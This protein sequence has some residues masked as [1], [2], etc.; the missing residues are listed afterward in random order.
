MRATRI[1]KTPLF[2]LAL[3]LAAGL[4]PAALAGV[5][6]ETVTFTKH[7]ARILQN[8]CQDCHHPN[9]IAPMTL[10]S[11][12][13]VK[14]WAKMIREVVDT[15]RMPPWHASPEYGHFSNDRSMAQTDADM[16]MSW[17]DNGMP[18]GDPADM[19]APKTYNDE[20]RIDEPDV[21]LTMP[22]E[23]HIEPSGV[24]PYE[25]IE[26]PTGFEEDKWVTQIDIRAGNPKVVHHVLVYAR[27]PEHQEQEMGEFL[28][29][30]R[31]FI[32]G[33]APGTVPVI[34][35]G[36][37]AIK[38]PKGANLIFQMHYTPTGKPEVDRS[39]IGL[40]FAEK[41]PEFEDLTAT[42][43]NFDFKIPPHADN[44]EVVADIEFP[45]SALLY[46]MTPH[47]HYRGKGFTYTAKYPDGT[48][49]ILLDVPRFD[50]NWQTSYVLETPRYIPAGTVLHTVAHFDNSANNPANPDPSKP[51]RWGDQTWEEMMIGWMTI[52]WLSPEQETKFASLDGYKPQPN[53]AQSK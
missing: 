23:V 29:L 48:E 3:A 27:A 14:G 8:N 12:R 52:S 7:V 36:T 53:V 44:H 35:D 17:I 10:Q 31:G 38:I 33:Y 24:M 21:V 47:M 2:G 13:Q 5:E 26:I 37:R 15:K 16:L 34:L 30:G 46:S 43:I 6:S 22:E 32:A 11:Y 19:P 20:W 4:C 51:V 49:E 41:A 1:P 50:F 25:N 40:K 9:G 18:Q 42:T 45:K 39:S 28:R